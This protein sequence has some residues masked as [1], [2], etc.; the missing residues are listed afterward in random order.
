MENAVHLSHKT[1]C[2]QICASKP[3]FICGTHSVKNACLLV[4]LLTVII[5]SEYQF[6][7]LEGVII[8]VRIHHRKKKPT[9]LT[10]TST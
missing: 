6:P 3:G 1:T 10:A 8:D 2:D 7:L 4:S 9:I 5:S